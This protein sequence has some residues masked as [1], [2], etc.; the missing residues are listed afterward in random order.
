MVYITWNPK[1]GLLRMVLPLYRSKNILLLTMKWPFSAQTP[2]L[3]PY[4]WAERSSVHWGTA[5]L[6]NTSSSEETNRSSCNT[7]KLPKLKRFLFATCST[8]RLTRIFNTSEINKQPDSSI[9]RQ[10][11]MLHWVLTVNSRKNIKHLQTS[12]FR[13]HLHSS[14]CFS[15]P[16]LSHFW[17]HQLMLSLDPLLCFK[18]AYIPQKSRAGSTHT[19]THRLSVPLRAS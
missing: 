1:V 16:C 2:H 10:T 6:Q 11:L 3:T 17:E 19:H 15:S 8:S 14:S 12:S 5:I 4:F 7:S 13:L 9:L 18:I